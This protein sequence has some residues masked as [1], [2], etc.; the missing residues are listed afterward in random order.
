MSLQENKAIVRQYL[1]AVW[2]KKNLAVIDEFI[3][4]D[5]VQHVHNVSPGREGIIKFFNMIYSSFSDAH[6]T[7]EDILAEDDK[8]M[9]RFTVRATHTGPFRG[10]LP[11]GKSFTL[12]GMAMTRMRDGQMVENW[13]EKWLSQALLLVKNSQR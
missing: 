5:L 12:T 3:A 1:E 9:W 13:N 8:V 11:T 7:I 2:N 6:L 10:I 4:P